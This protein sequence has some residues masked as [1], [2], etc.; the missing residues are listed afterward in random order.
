LGLA[1]FGIRGAEVQQCPTLAALRFLVANNGRFALA[2]KR[3]LE[4]A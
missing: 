1:W 2:R 4:L 3:T